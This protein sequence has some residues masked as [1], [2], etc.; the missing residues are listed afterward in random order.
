MGV[1]K[2]GNGKPPAA[3][4]YYPGGFI[5][6]ENIAKLSVIKEVFN[7]LLEVQGIQ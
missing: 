4:E 3:L 2:N 7:K 6:S 5:F 1:L